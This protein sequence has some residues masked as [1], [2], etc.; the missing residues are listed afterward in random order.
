MGFS[1]DIRNLL[2]NG[3]SSKGKLFTF[4]E[5]IDLLLSR[6]TTPARSNAR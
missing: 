3:V 5:R 6:L 4:G 2:E 1:A